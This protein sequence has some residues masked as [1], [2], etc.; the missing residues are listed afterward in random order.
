M[1]HSL[2]EYHHLRCFV[3]NVDVPKLV[4]FLKLETQV[5]VIV[6]E[7]STIGHRPHIHATI[8]FRKA[9]NTFRDKFKKEFPQLFGN[10]SYSITK[11]KNYDSNIKY[12]LKGVPNDYPDVLYSTLTD[13]EIKQ[14][15]NE[16]WE[17]QDSILKSKAKSKE[18]NMG[19]L[20]D[21]SC[22]SLLVPKAKSKTWSEKL[23]KY[24][25][26]EYPLL[27]QG[28][29][30]YHS[31]QKTVDYELLHETLVGII[32]EHLGKHSKN[33][34]EFILIRLYNAQLNAI[35]QQTGDD[36]AKRN[37]KKELSGKI[38]SKTF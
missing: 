6:H 23:T 3:E 19:C 14:Y 4:E 9:I 5:L 12:C 8:R 34:D 11:V 16:Y 35:I 18:V 10:K 20:N 1:E 2:G 33:L 17:V 21:P 27:C 31:G 28:F 29:T 15:Y 22:N 25:I 38:K 36:Q 26:D 30:Q 13:D 37:F 7:I 32:L 24:I